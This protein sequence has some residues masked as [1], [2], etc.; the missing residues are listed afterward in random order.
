MN[1][2]I[3]HLCFALTVSTMKTILF[4]ILSIIY[5][6]G[7]AQCPNWMNKPVVNQILPTQVKDMGTGW[8]L[9]PGTSDEFTGTSLNISKWNA[10]NNYCHGMSPYAYFKYD[11]LNVSVS[12][13]RL[14]LSCRPDNPFPCSGVNLNYSTGYVFMRTPSQ[15]GYIEIKCKLPNEAL[16]NPCFWMY[17]GP[18]NDYDEIDV[19]EYILGDPVNY[20]L[21]QNV[22]HNLFQSDQTGQNLDIQF[23]QPF[24]G[25]DIIFAIEW[26]PY[27]INYLINGQ[28]TACTKYTTEVGYISPQGYKPRSEFTCV[29]FDNANAQN[30]Q[31]SL[32]LSNPTN[33][34]SEGF[35]VDY[36][37]SYKLQE[38][39][40]GLYWPSII[41][42]SDVNLSKVHLETK[43]GG[44][45]HNGVV[46]QGSNINIWAHNSVILDK[47][48]TV[49]TSTSFTAR[50][51]RTAPA[52]FIQ[53]GPN[54]DNNNN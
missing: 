46:P 2:I 6:D 10:Y 35:E 42:L 30:Y 32:S 45:S 26:L 52:L 18:V 4:F 36:I 28:V 9:N 22:A 17:G 39:I 29:N 33:N 31:V 1:K 47:G 24:T 49:S 11:P 5:F 15:Y 54:Q 3:N 53:T 40:N 8:I 27:E 44:D 37:R 34:L 7:S 21:R 23:D 51:V 41:S 50:T 19:W 13:G 43:L 38:G 12:N 25:N 16:L 20:K 48:F 14:K